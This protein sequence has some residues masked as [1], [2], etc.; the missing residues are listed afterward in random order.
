MRCRNFKQP[1]KSLVVQ[2]ALVSYPNSATLALTSWQKVEA[3]VSML[4]SVAGLQRRRVR[5]EKVQDD[6]DDSDDEANGSSH[7]EARNGTGAFCQ[8]SMKW[9]A[10][11]ARS[12]IS[13]IR[14]S[15]LFAL[16]RRS[17][18]Q[19]RSILCHGS[20]AARM[21]CAP[22]MQSLTRSQCLQIALGSRF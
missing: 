19:L 9:S 21:W 3:Y 10:A 2:E 5:S 15:R 8:G 18:E 4:V 14:N 6:A 12:R 20:T 11:C 13:R 1:L 16:G 17:R 7:N 22:H